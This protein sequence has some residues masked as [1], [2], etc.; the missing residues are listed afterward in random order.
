MI[1]EEEETFKQKSI[2]KTCMRE[3]SNRE[4]QTERDRTFAQVANIRNG[5]EEDLPKNRGVD[6]ASDL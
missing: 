1:K 6:H 4:E 5:D 3:R 2:S